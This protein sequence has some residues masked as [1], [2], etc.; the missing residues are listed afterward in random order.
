MR[1]TSHCKYDALKRED[2]LSRKPALTCTLC[3]D[4]V[5]SCHA[6]SIQ[7]KLFSLKLAMSRNI[8]LGIT[9]TLHAMTMVLAKI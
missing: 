3:G 2:I 1:C 8:Y 4:C 7:Y 6:G 5:T 9:I